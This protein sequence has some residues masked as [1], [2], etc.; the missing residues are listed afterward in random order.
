MRKLKVGNKVK[1]VN[2]GSCMRVSKPNPFQNQ[3]TYPILWEEE[4]WGGN[5]YKSRAY[6]TCWNNR[7]S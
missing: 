6:R 1:I 5:R 3:G 2:Y 7:W 4:H